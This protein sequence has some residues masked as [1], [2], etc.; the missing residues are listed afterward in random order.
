MLVRT[1][2]VCPYRDCKA[3]LRSG[4]YRIQVLIDEQRNVILQKPQDI[5]GSK[6]TYKYDK[7]VRSRNCP[8]C[9]KVVEVVIDETHEGRNL[10]IR[11]PK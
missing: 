6:L 9:D 4:P 3:H 11:L 5:Q 8:Y 10:N 2:S 7:W 1:H